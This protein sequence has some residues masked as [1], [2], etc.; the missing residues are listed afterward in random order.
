M[1]CRRGPGD[2][3]ATVERL[4]VGLVGAGRSRNGLGPFLASY[5]EQAGARVVGVAGSSPASAQR[6]AA[7]LGQRLGHPVAAAADLAAL[8]TA[9]LDALVIAS[10]A[11]HHLEALQHALAAGVPV[12]CEKPLVEPAQH[13]SG[14]E[15]AAAFAAR[16]LL[17]A[18]NCQWPFVLPAFRQL[19]AA[20]AERPPRSVQLMLSP[21]GQGRAMVEDSLPH[22]LSVLQALWP[23]DAAARITAVHC[24]ELLPHTSQLELRLSLSLPTGD[25]EATLHLQRCLEQPRPAWLQLDGERMD[26]RIGAD[27]RI[28]FVDHD[29]PARAVAA[30]DPLRALVSDFV[31]VLAGSDAG[32]IAAMTA[33]VRWRLDAYHQV[34]AQLP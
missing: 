24:C 21:S 29:D 27:Y 20:R 2:Y 30:E 1:D 22:L 11:E 31:A 25:V 14:R 18:E 28:D 12:L 4:A 6:A 32:R 23:L 13:G 10:P 17:L 5:L 8:L 7:A 19:F 15:V 16:G 9:P 26:R 3:A 34:L 33:A